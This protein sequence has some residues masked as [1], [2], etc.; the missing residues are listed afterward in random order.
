MTQYCYDSGL[1]A[2][3]LSLYFGESRNLFS[4]WYDFVGSHVDQRFTEDE[5]A[6]FEKGW[7]CARQTGDLCGA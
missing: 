5:F 4:A 6:A 1:A 3:S 2:A 7:S